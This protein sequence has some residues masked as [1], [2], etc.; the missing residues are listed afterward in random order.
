MN[1]ELKHLNST[2]LDSQTKNF[3]QKH[4]NQVDPKPKN[5][6]ELRD[7]LEP[8]LFLL[9]E[10]NQNKDQPEFLKALEE[11]KTQGTSLY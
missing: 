1:R 10:F 8:L 5:Y 3:V 4:R 7:V 11:S 9:K 6:Y 2:N